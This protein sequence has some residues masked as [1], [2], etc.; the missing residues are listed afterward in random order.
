M[1]NN[2]RSPELVTATILRVER[3]EDG[4]CFAAF[5]FEFSTPTFWPVSF[6]PD[7]CLGSEDF[8]LSSRSQDLDSNC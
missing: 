6:P 1:L 7:D 3:S 2:C 5:E 8:L 4:R